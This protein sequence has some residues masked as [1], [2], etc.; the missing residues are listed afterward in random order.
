MHAHGREAARRRQGAPSTKAQK[1][2]FARRRRRLSG[3]LHFETLALIPYLAA[4]LR[5]EP[6]LRG[7]VRAAK[8]EEPML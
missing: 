3:L 4:K 8:A 1:A 7:E 5:E 2:P 6:K